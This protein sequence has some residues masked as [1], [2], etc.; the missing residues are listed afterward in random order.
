M[1]HTDKLIGLWPAAGLRARSGPLE[2]RWINDRLLA[3]L[4]ELA[5]EGIHAP[6]QMPFTVP[7]SR[8]TK[9]QVARNVLEYQWAVRSQVGPG[10]LV[11]EMAVLL[12]GVPVGVQAA[13][14]DNWAILRSVETGSWLGR[15]QQGRGLGTRMRALMLHLLFDG[16]H[17]REVRSTAFAD[18]HASNAV[19][20]KTG[21]LPDGR[22]RDVREGA[23]VTVNRYRMDVERFGHRRDSLAGLLGA[24]VEISGA[25][26]VRDRL[27]GAG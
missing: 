4:A 25:E 9:D 11:L 6:G 2:L 13:S 5:A 7:W 26:P 16:L 17:A 1:E 12:D 27:A 3:E 23:P 18:N 20:I 10:K 14:G 8:G 21:Y 19:S 15:A 22:F 24:P